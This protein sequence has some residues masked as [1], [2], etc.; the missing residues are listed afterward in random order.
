LSSVDGPPAARGS[1]HD[2]RR[3]R[4]YQLGRVD[5][6]TLALRVYQWRRHRDDLD[7]Y[8]VT[9]ERAAR[10]LGVNLT[11]LNQLATRGFV[12]FEIHADGTRLYRREQLEVV[13]NARA[14]RWDARTA[15]HR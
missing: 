4:H 15:A 13:S 2:D 11:R 3:Y 5:V 8:W 12:P 7:P 1:R 14:V 9:G 10:I 6:E